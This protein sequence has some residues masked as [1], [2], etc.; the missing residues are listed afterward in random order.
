MW[1]VSKCAKGTTMSNK[2]QTSLV[3]KDKLRCQHLNNDQVNVVVFMIFMTEPNSS[4]IPSHLSPRPP[5]T[6]NCKAADLSPE[7]EHSSMR[8]NTSNIVP[9]TVLKLVKPQKTSLNK[10]THQMNSM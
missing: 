1:Y 6:S 2:H 8:K 9:L 10:Y 5:L 4:F 7:K 3:Q